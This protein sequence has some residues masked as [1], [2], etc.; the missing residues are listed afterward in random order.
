MSISVMLNRVSWNVRPLHR[1]RGTGLSALGGLGPHALVIDGG[2][3]SRN[4]N[5]RQQ[6]STQVHVKMRGRAAHFE[7]LGDGL[8]RFS[9]AGVAAGR[10][11]MALR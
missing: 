10:S 8:A 6:W 1:R 3:S 4:V 9:L 11:R 5:P 2:C 7:G